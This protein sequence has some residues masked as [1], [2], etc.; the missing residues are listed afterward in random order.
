MRAVILAAGVGSRLAPRTNDRP[1]ALVEVGG[2][3][4]LARL[5]RQ[6][7]AVGVR[8]LI[9]AAGH[10]EQA[11]ARAL[12]QIPMKSTICRNAAFDRTQNVVSLHVCAEAILVDGPRETWK[13]DGDLWLDDQ[14]IEGL[15]ARR[16]AHDDLLCAVDGRDDLGAEEMKVRIEGER[17]V[18]F[19]KHLD[20]RAAHG[21]SMG[22]ERLGPRAVSSILHGV[23][24]AVTAGETHLYYEDVYDRAISAGIPASA[25]VLGHLPWTEI[26]TPDDLARAEMLAALSLQKPDG[27]STAALGSPVVTRDRR[28][29]PGKLT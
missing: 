11:V 19:G 13:L 21:E 6:L 9:V 17:I 7:G 20:P 12:E 3:S 1:K 15:A 26:D 5:A 27:R 18:A 25:V 10:A 2:E 8:E 23:S 22:I 16:L 14:V 28:K 29:G 24:R 4:L